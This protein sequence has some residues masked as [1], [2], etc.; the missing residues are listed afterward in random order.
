[1]QC[2]DL[3]DLARDG[4]RVAVLGC[5]DVS[6][7]TDL[8]E[9]LKSIGILALRRVDMHTRISEKS[10]SQRLPTRGL[11]MGIAGS[12]RLRFAQSALLLCLA[13]AGIGIST[14]AF[15]DFRVCNATQ[16][17][18]G[19][20]I[21]YRA[22]DGWKTEGWWQIDAS[23]CKTLIEGGLSSRFYYLYAE[24]AERGGRWEGPINMCV[25]EKEF[26]IVGVTD[27][28]ARGFQRAGFKE[29]DT[30]EQSSWMVQLTDDPAS[31]ATTPPVSG[32]GPTEAEGE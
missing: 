31:G 18:V 10:L 28:F 5:P 19:V 21:G 8:C 17:L 4:R 3:A 12:R 6:L 16:N 15:A 20:A 26:K 25:A 2:R 32:A 11:R 27:C 30:G 9:T 1:M 29:Y 14:P 7:H 13:T 24:D 22:T 23:T